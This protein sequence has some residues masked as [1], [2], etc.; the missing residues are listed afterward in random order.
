ME[1]LTIGQ[2]A[3][4]ANVNASTIRYYESIG[5]LPEPKRV[6]G[7]RR[8]SEE[9]LNRMKFIKIGQQVGFSVQEIH[10]LVDG[11][12][13]GSLSHHWYSMAMKKREE[14]KKKQ[15]QMDMMINILED[16]LRCQCLTWEDCFTYIKTNKTLD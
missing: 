4:K 8:Y 14:L 10:S 15:E 3:E 13:A 2:I 1:H 12:E 7:Q 16:G 9:I 11:L 5:L 6:K